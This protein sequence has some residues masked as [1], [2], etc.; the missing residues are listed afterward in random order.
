MN[1]ELAKLADWLA[2][3][4][5]TIIA[6]RTKY[7]LFHSLTNPA[8]HDILLYINKCSLKCTDSLSYLSVV[9][10]NCLKWQFQLDAAC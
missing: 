3:N 5:L 9:L 7:M 8:P 1:D 6:K 4:R 2:A 10:D